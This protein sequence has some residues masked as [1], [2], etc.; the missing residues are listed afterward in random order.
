LRAVQASVVIRARDEARAIGRT[1]EIL[2]AQTL[3]HEVILVDSGSRDATP[4]I[5]RDRGARVLRIPSEGFNYGRALNLGCAE[6]DAPV[7]VALSAHA[8]PPGADW[9]ERMVAHFDDAAVAC[10]YGERHDET[11]APLREAVRQDASRLE[12]WPYWGYSNSA[13][14]FRADLWRD[15]PFREDMPGSEDREWSLWALRRG[16]VCVLDPALAVD[17]DHSKDPLRECFARY[18]RE[19]RG[20]AMFLGL[21]EYGV[22]DLLREWWGDQGGHRSRLR[23]RL[24]PRRVARLAGKWRGRRPARGAA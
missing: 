2:A 5:A 9:L 15:R 1:L 14:G 24:D 18:E 10:A 7:L 16:H 11:W 3:P 13:G 12:R 19:H 6:A 22:P 20:L 21:R 8:W 17:H 4:E 23:A